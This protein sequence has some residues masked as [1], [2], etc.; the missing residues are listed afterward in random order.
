M[1][2]VPVS[3][4][5]KL[6]RLCSVLSLLLLR[7]HS[8]SVP[9]GEIS[10]ELKAWHKVTL[11]VDGPEAREKDDDPNPFLDLRMTVRFRH[12]SGEP[13]YDVPGY[14][15][16]DG[17]AAESSATRGDKW[18]AHLS[19]DKAGKWTYAVSF[20]Q[21]GA[22][23]LQGKFEVVASDKSGGGFPGKRAAGI[24]RET[25]FAPCRHGCVVFESGR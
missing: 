15:A 3:S 21:S 7:A 4:F 24:C 6:A 17:N 10:G 8:Q 25:L 18:R 2:S 23:G 9:P 12:E 22:D 5:G 13:E 19:P 16:V 20:P 1:L 11:T 14:F